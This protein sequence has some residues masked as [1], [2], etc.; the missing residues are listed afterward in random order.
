[1]E[2]IVQQL[3]RSEAIK[4]SSETDLSGLRLERTQTLE[5]NARSL[6]ACDP[7]NYAKLHK[8]AIV[9]FSFQ[10]FIKALHIFI[11]QSTHLFIHPSIY[12]SIYPCIHLR[13]DHLS[14]YSLI[15][16]LINLLSYKSINPC[17][18]PF[19][20]TSIHSTK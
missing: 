9:C 15:Y 8:E 6:E 11:Y 10:Q 3:G 7:E 2:D 18:Y 5:C 19:I 14:M 20:N 1:M 16:S 17:I 13:A 12:Q 4:K